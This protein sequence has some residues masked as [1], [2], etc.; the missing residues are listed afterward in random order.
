MSD[1]TQPTNTPAPAE[2]KDAVA[3]P[4]PATESQPGFGENPASALPTNPPAPNA[5]PLGG[6]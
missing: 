4:P 3:P 5:P 6:P 1:E 2:R